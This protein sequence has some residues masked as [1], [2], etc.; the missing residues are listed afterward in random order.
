MCF[1]LSAFSI[2]LSFIHVAFI[3]SSFLMLSSISLNGYTNVFIHS[4][5]NWYLIYIQIFSYHKKG[6][7]IFL[8]IWYRQM[9]TFL[10]G[11]Y[12]KVEY[13]GHKIGLCLT[14][15]LPNCFPKC[16]PLYLLISSVLKF[17]LLHILTNTWYV[18]LLN[19]SHSSG[20]VVVSHCGSNV[21]FPN[22]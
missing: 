13:L 1:C 9:L 6:V 12:V 17:Q 7:N 19:F 21:H 11:K 14:L 8:W 4:P 15:K 2:I 5:V 16:L 18:S 22:D 10:L 3:D 20:S